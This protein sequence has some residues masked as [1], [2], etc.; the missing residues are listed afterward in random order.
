MERAIG[1]KDQ[2][3]LYSGLSSSFHTRR[4]KTSLETMVKPESEYKNTEH[5]INV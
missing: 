3:K 2:F 5:D 4:K 1:E